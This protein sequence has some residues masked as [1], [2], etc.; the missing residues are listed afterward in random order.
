MILPIYAYGQPVLKKVADPITPDYPELAEFIANMW[1]TMY[2][3]E[4]VGLAAPQV[5]QGIRLFVVDT[6]QLEK[7]G[8]DDPKPGFKK[9]FINAQMVEETGEL[10]TYEE[11]C[12][13][14]PRISGDV[15]RMPTIRLRYQDENF[16]QFEE[17]FTGVNARVI[18]HEYD[19]IQGVLFTEHLK[20]LKKRLIR[21]KLEN[22]RLGN[23]ETDYKMRF[24]KAR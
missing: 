12:L 19:H 3:A 7:E 23:I 9:V 24:V 13:S 4:G 5:G 10:W 18:Q 1:E 16:E 15:E 17:T 2:A 22:I 20:P 11:G 21:R 14:I 8:K 6:Q